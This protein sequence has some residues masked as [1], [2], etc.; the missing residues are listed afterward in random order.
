MFSVLTFPHIRRGLRWEMCWWKILCFSR[1]F[2][3]A[4]QTILIPHPTNEN[5]RTERWTTSGLP[6]CDG[7]N[8]FPPHPNLFESRISEQFPC[9]RYAPTIWMRKQRICT[10][11][12]IS[13]EKDRRWTWWWWI[14][15]C[16]RGW[17]QERANHFTDSWNSTGPRGGALIHLA[18]IMKLWGYSVC[19][20]WFSFAVHRSL[21]RKLEP[22]IPRGGTSNVG[23]FIPKADLQSWMDQHGNPAKCQHCIR[24][25]LISIVACSAASLEIVFATIASCMVVGPTLVW[26]CIAKSYTGERTIATKMMEKWWRKRLGIILICMGAQIRS[27]H[28]ETYYV[29]RWETTAK[30][31]FRWPHWCRS[32]SYMSSERK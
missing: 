25:F 5:P 7:W 6:S 29:W 31:K 23:I 22:I 15:G 3:F 18:C 2:C 16:V 10:R 30:Y 4:W 12:N 14:L 27:C 11:W 19:R 28:Q 8:E 32:S 1:V 21:C 20:M 17:G 24:R 26:V 13:L 9:F